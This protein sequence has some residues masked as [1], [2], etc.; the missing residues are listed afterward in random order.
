MDVGREVQ[1]FEAAEAARREPLERRSLVVQNPN[2]DGLALRELSF[3]RELGV[4]VSRLRRAGRAEVETVRDDSR[5]HVGDVV[6]AVAPQRVL[7]RLQLAVG[8]RAAEDLASAPGVVTNRR[9]V[10]TRDLVLGQPIRTLES[11]LGVTCTRVTRS[12]LE[13]AARP[14][15]AVQFGDVLQVVGTETAVA[16][17]ATAVGN[18][19]RELDVT[20]FGAV[21]LGIVFGI[22]L[23]SVRIALP[24]LPVALRLGLAGGPL[25]A[26]IALSAIGRLGR[27]VFYMPANANLA[28][29][30]FGITLFMAS[31]GLGAGAHF[32]AHP[33]TLEILG[34]LAASTVV[35]VVPL[36][37]VGV[38]AR[39][40]R[41]LDY[42]RLCG[43]V[44]GSMTDPPALAFGNTLLG[45]DAASTT[46]AAVYPLTMLLRVITAQML[47]LLAV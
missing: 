43:L 33:L 41:R 23:G 12:G 14:E 4:V 20:R 34:W 16:E 32:A 37:A 44:A 39:L 31:V 29:R 30:E 6:L 17:A 15:L 18:A 35:T 21:F 27:I 5:L 19:A 3:L 10:V 1:A 22:A 45:G 9:V 13:L 8:A 46:Y 42:V 47:A 40:V 38:V 24:G 36:L 2:L 26:A 11:R 25:V 7:D 28:L